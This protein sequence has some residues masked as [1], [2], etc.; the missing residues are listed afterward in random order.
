MQKKLY[1]LA[2]Y[3]ACTHNIV[4][5]MK[6]NDTLT[7]L[8]NIYKTDDVGPAELY[9]TEDTTGN[10]VYNADGGNPVYNADGGNPVYSFNENQYT[11]YT[12]GHYEKNLA[13]SF[14]SFRTKEENILSFPG[15]YL[16]RN[17]IGNRKDGKKHAFNYELEAVSHIE[18]LKCLFNKQIP[19]RCWE[20]HCYGFWRGCS[21]I[22]AL[23]SQ[24]PE[25][26]DLRARIFLPEDDR[27]KIL[28]SLQLIIAKNPMLNAQRHLEKNITPTIETG[29]FAC[30]A[31]PPIVHT[32]TV[33]LCNNS[34]NPLYFTTVPLAIFKKPIALQASFWGMNYYTSIDDRRA[35]GLK[36]LYKLT[37]EG[38]KLGQSLVLAWQADDPVTGSIQPE[39]LKLLHTVF[40]NVCFIGGPS[41]DHN[42][43]DQRQIRVINYVRHVENLPHYTIPELLN[44]GKRH[45]EEILPY[46]MNEDW[47][48][49]KEYTEDPSQYF[50]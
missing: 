41:N 35:D 33:A 45:Y 48:G 32:S 43:I 50:L 29:L 1:A 37:K 25:A 24:T 12:P 9:M 44:A 31:I 26:R 3:I 16:A 20:T 11:F 38:I 4:L 21:T 47:E 30:S 13:K 8:K 14:S 49:L 2:L 19:V 27:K 42:Y 10:P 22:Y 28:R 7:K 17:G 6:E 15:T 40:N 36:L 23:A 5:T 18:T 39:D 34:F 46:H